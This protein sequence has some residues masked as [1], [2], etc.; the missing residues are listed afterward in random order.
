[1]LTNRNLKQDITYWAWDN[2]LDAYNERAFA[3]PVLLKGRWA[4]DAVTVTKSNGD[5]IVSKAVVHLN[6]EVVV[7]GYL[8]LGNFL[9]VPSPYTAEAFEI[10]AFQSVPD[11][12]AMEQNRKAYL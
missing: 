7:G 9:S 4:E 3:A 11:L 5:E 1:M 12:R 10:Q 6:R 8:A 2:T